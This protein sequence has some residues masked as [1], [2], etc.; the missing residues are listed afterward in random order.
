L[1]H[2]HPPKPDDAAQAFEFRPPADVPYRE[3][4]WLLVR[5]R[6]GARLAGHLK[7]ATDLLAAG[8]WH[9]GF[10]MVADRLHGSGFAQRLFDAY[11]GWAREHGARWAR[12][13]VVEGNARAHAFWRRQGYVEV[14]RAA[15]Y[16]LGEQSHTLITMVKP[17]A[18]PLAEYLDAVPRD[19]SA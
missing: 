15:G 7:I 2:G 11:E 18:A 19:R 14:R 4:L 16:V 3:H 12:L 6:H 10:F 9:L 17:L 1:T 8:V 5:E 13:G